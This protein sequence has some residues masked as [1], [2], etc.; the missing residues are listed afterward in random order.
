MILD[1]AKLKQSCKHMEFTSTVNK[2]R[3]TTRVYLKYKNE[4]IIK[5]KIVKYIHLGNRVSL[6]SIKREVAKWAK[7]S[8]SSLI[9][10]DI[11]TRCVTIG[12]RSSIRT[13]RVE[14]WAKVSASS[15]IDMDIGN[16]CVTIG[17][18][19]SIRTER[20]EFQQ[21]NKLKTNKI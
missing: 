11:G 10:M 18:R 16:R 3:W 2:V 15:L 17:V 9:G 19:S 7:V 4:N 8:A 20:A 6:S 14:K 21:T 1:R 13:E 5:N 12:V